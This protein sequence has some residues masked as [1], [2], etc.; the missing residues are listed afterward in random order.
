VLERLNRV[1]LRWILKKSVSVLCAY[2]ARLIAKISMTINFLCE[3][4]AIEPAL[5]RFGIAPEQLKELLKWINTL[6]DEESKAK[7]TLYSSLLQNLSEMAASILYR[8]PPAVAVA[9]E[10]VKAS[11]ELMRIL[12]EIDHFTRTK[13]LSGLVA[14][15]SA[16]TYQWERILQ[17]SNIPEYFDR[18][19]IR[20]KMREII[21]QNKG[22]ILCPSFDIQISGSNCFLLV[23]GWDIN[24]LVEEEVIEK[25]EQEEEEKQEEEEMGMMTWVCAACTFENPAAFNLCEIC[26]TPAPVA[27]KQEEVYDVIEATDL[28]AAERKLKEREAKRF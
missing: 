19:S 1:F 27:A 4:N 16:P 17:V 25:I 6:T 15:P 20:H 12:K 5:E 24:E 28:R 22:K 10:H 2:L 11:I 3:R 9:P 26:Q 8:Q 14:S 18:N 21:Q 7:V 13:K 23:D